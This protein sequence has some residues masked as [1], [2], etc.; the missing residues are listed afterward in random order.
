MLA[1]WKT[2]GKGQEYPYMSI[3]RSSSI[4]IYSTAAETDPFSEDDSWA[5]QST[6]QIAVEEI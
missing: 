2:E 3:P 1:L 5:N 4:A 6:S